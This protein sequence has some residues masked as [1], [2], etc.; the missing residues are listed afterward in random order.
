MKTLKKVLSLLLC[1]AAAVS[2]NAAAHGNYFTADA[3]Y[4]SGSVDGILDNTKSAY[5]TYIH[6]EYN[7]AATLASG[8]KVAVYDVWGKYDTAKFDSSD[9]FAITSPSSYYISSITCILYNNDG[10]YVKPKIVGFEPGQA[11]F[12][13]FYFQKNGVYTSYSNSTSGGQAKSS[14]DVVEVVDPKDS[15]DKTAPVINAVITAANSSYASVNIETDELSSLTVNGKTYSSCTGVDVNF[16]SNGTYTISATDVNGNTATRDIVISSI[17]GAQQVTTAPPVTTT[18]PVTTVQPTTTAKPV[19]TVKPTTTAKPV[20]TVQSTTTAKP[21]TTVKPTTT[22]KPVTTVQPTT[23]AKPITTVQPTTT[24]KPIT[25][26]QPTTTA[27]PITTVKPTTTVPVTTATQSP[28]GYGIVP[29]DSAQLKPGNTITLQYTAGTPQVYWL[30]PSDYSM[31]QISGNN[32]TLQKEGTVTI[33]AHCADNVDVQITL[34]VAGEAQA[35]TIGDVDG[36]GK[37][38]ASDASFVLVAYSQLSTGRGS[39][40]ETWQETAAD[41]NGDGKIDASDAS[42]ILVYYAAVS[43]GKTPTWNKKN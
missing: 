4:V 18:K 21:V 2:A 42:D 25:T 6:W 17:G 10:S 12:C 3:V 43:T 26:V 16:S 13:T 34:T 40:L 35:A 20:T 38:D 7:K 8:S 29:P 1:G 28:S 9:K 30:E 27:K 23:T 19:T 33:T 41:V 5:K 22:A 14:I 37:I 36:N 24:A 15:S 39:G 32:V 31:V 11:A